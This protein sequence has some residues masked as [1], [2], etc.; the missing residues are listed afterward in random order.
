MFTDGCQGWRG[1]GKGF[2]SLLDLHTPT[3]VLLLLVA[4]HGLP[5]PHGGGRITSWMA[6][7]SLLS[8]S[9]F[10]S[11][12]I[13]TL[14]SRPRASVAQKSYGAV[15]KASIHPMGAYHP[16]GVWGGLSS[17]PLFAVLC[18]FSPLQ[19]PCSLAQLCPSQGAW[20]RVAPPSNSS[21]TSTNFCA[22]A[23]V[24]V[25]VHDPDT[26]CVTLAPGEQC[27]LSPQRASWCC[28]AQS[29]F[30]SE[31]RRDLAQSPVSW[32]LCLRESHPAFA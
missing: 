31:D 14:F 28:T 6:C 15:E 23:N 25:R 27:F 10:L 13:L 24:L 8:G 19:A 32:L 5:S 22:P 30:L 17:V 16:L 11:I 20:I 12:A 3:H 18:S 2:L 9:F 26:S 29:D 1:S 7:C 21:F 4:G